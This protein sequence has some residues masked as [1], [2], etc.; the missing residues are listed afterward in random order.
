[1]L[2]MPFIVSVILSTIDLFLV[3]DLSLKPDIPIGCNG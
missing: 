1:V 2:A 3:H